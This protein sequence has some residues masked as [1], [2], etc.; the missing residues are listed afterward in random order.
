M[1]VSF[2]RSVSQQ[3]LEDDEEDAFASTAH[4]FLGVA[5]AK[6]GS[7]TDLKEADGCYLRAIAADPSSVPGWQGRAALYE[8]HGAVLDDPNTNLIEAYSGFLKHCTDEA[9]CQEARPKLAKAF[10]N[11]KRDDE[12]FA[13]YKEC[14]SEVSKALLLRCRRP[15]CRTAALPH[16]RTAAVRHC[17]LTARW[18]GWVAPHPCATAT[19]RSRRAVQH[20]AASMVRLHAPRHCRA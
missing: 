20:A 11:L 16:C 2:P 13:L 10:A 3:V 4:V 12:A 8:K 7:A 15:H 6:K 14:L 1:S 9:K 5:Y 18:R 19:A 17:P